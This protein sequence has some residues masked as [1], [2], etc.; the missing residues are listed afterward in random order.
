MAGIRWPAPAS[1]S[2]TTARVFATLIT[3]L[4]EKTSPVFVI[5]TANNVE[6]LPPELLRQGR[7]DEIFFVDLPT[8]EERADIFR[9]HLAKRKRDPK[10]FDIK[11]L[12]EASPNY[13]GAE[14]EQS[15]ISA[16]HDAFDTNQD[17]NQQILIDAIGK[18]SPLSRV[19]AEEIEARRRWAQGRTRPA[20]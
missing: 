7:F 11:A 18:T 12:V 14:I 4:Q 1:D 5:A 15:I 16:L 9:I 8:A 10:R 17:I 20:S 3:W 2:G 13:S 6:Q 19:M